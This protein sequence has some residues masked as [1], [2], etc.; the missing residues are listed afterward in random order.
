MQLC[1]RRLRMATL[2]V[3]DGKAGHDTVLANP[4]LFGNFN[5]HS[6]L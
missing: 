5:D 1:L 6:T 4:Y 3:L 2:Y